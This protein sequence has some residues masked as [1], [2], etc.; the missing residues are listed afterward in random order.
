MDETYVKVRNK[1]VYLYRAVDKHG[2]TVDFML[3]ET[4]DEAAATASL[5]KSIGTNGLPEKVVMDKSGAD[6]AGL[7]NINIYLLLVGFKAFHSA[8]ATLCGIEIARMIGN[9]QLNQA[10][11]PA[12][13]QFMA[14]AG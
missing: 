8:S 2:D 4:R 13:R 7:T 3:S 1:W 12:Y 5:T 10:G 14:L 11:V 6:L 9:G